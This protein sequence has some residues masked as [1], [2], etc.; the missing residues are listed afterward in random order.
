MNCRKGTNLRPLNDSIVNCIMHKTPLQAADLKL[1][2]SRT[3]LFFNLLSQYFERIL[4]QSSIKARLSVQIGMHKLKILSVKQQLLKKKAW[5]K[6]HKGVEIAWEQVHSDGAFSERSRERTEKNGERESHVSLLLTI[7]LAR[8]GLHRQNAKYL[9]SM[10]QTSEPARK[11]EQKVLPI[12][13]G[14]AQ[15]A[16]INW[17]FVPITQ[18]HLSLSR[19]SLFTGNRAGKSCRNYFPWTKKFSG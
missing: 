15:T 18:D 9:Q 17:K 12:T 13:A 6:I 3:F 19:S 4:I 16:T 2:K 5:K 1:L 14:H 11:L 7:F 8:W 10:P